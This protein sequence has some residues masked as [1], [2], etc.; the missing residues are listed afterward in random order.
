MIFGSLLTG[1]TLSFSFGLISLTNLF[2]LVIVFFFIEKKSQGSTQLKTREKE[3]GF[4]TD[5]IIQYFKHGTLSM[6][7]K[8]YNILKAKGSISLICFISLY[9]VGENGILNLLPMLL[10]DSGTSKEFLSVYI[11]SLGILFS[12]LGS[13]LGEIYLAENYA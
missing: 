11:T 5:Q 9:K 8:F 2:C 7:R 13:I 10:L 12:L 6:R 3:N 4:L 1:A